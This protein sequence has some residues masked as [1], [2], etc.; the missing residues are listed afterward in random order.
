MN[1]DHFLQVNGYG[2]LG[3]EVAEESLV[4]FLNLVNP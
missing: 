1:L 4:V 2:K 3:R